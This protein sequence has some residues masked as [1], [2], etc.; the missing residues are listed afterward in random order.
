MTKR[1]IL[2]AFVLCITFAL[3]A[4]TVTIKGIVIG[5][6]T[7]TPIEN[8]SIHVKRL[9]IGT[10]TSNNGRFALQL[11]TGKHI[12]TV[13]KMGYKTV[14]HTISTADIQQLHFELA[15]KIHQLKEVSVTQKILR[16]KE[17][18]SKINV[19]A[20]NI[21]ITTSVVNNQLLQ[22]ADIDNVNDALRYTTGINPRVNYGG[23]QTF[24]MRGFG[25]PVFMIDG[26]RDERMN[27]S[28]SAPITSLA[29][30]D[31]IEYLKGPASVLYGHSAVGGILNIIRKKP[32][33]NFTANFAATYGSWNTKKVVLG[34]GGKINKSLTYRFDA[35]LSNS[36]GW[37][38][39]NTKY[40]NVY[41]AFNQKL[42]ENDN[43]E[44][45][46][47]ANDDFYGTETG[48]P[49]IN[50]DIIYD[51]WGNKIAKRGDLL[52]SF[53]KKQR[54]NDPNDFLKGKN[55]N[56][57]AKYIHRINKKSYISFHAS[58]SYDLIDYFSTESLSFPTS[59][60]AIYDHY[61]M[62]NDK[63]KYIDLKHLI[64]DY[65][66]RF[67][68]ETKTYQN[69]LEYTN[70]FN[71]G[72]ITHNIMGGYYFMYVDRISFSGYN[73]GEDVYGDGL[74]A[75]ITIQNPILNQGNLESKFS[76]ASLYNEYVNSFYFHDLIDISAKIKAMI[77][78]R[79]DFYSMNYQKA[80]VTEGRNISEKTAK[81]SILNTPLSYRV[82]LVYKPI[83]SLSV[84][85]SI[86]SFFKPQRSVY[87]ENYIYINKDG[88]VFFPKDGEEVFKPE[89]G[90]QAEIGAKY[91]FRK[92]LQLSAAAYYIK[93]ENI[94]QYLGKSKDNK[95]IYGQIGVV[96][97]KG[98]ELEANITTPISGLSVTT[99]YGYC[100]A[101]YQKF[102]TNKYNADSKEGNLFSYSPRNQFYA[103]SFYKIPSG[104]L[105]NL[106]AGF[107]INYTDKQ[108]TNTSNTYVLPSHWLAE[109]TLGYSFDNIY[110]KL[111][112]NNL[113]NKSYF[114]NS[115]F[116]SQFVPGRER[117]VMFT[118]GLKL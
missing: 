76:A 114:S 37:R 41:V 5:K 6:K 43:L 115:I 7:K 71:T 27:F 116:S 51:T 53:H 81:K 109:A 82:G 56:A 1:L 59:D 4:Q 85:A 101:T 78:M 64:R 68:H 23:F 29:A 117:N 102:S 10:T 106:S 86:A 13:S 57:S 91:K 83:E 110:F 87:N 19:A 34:A 100:D 20:Q 90:Y 58:Y 3:K 55:Y 72:N 84:Y 12:I 77:G 33:D 24:K 16:N 111:K 80:K 105:Q 66:L 61:Y 93:K 32:T 73:L 15:Q 94:K 39:N 30:V 49:V 46:L 88:D 98:F 25:S 70:K 42:S 40:S 14:R 95:R 9:Q 26:S 31:R 118:V 2:L 97:S 113:F 52:K 103:W 22:Q 108:Y 48:L 21:P 69:F 35:S 63:K 79:I 17:R 112:V 99:G 65:P 44:I 96:D 67:S 18:I 107:G 8:V 74:Y 11:P 50:K 38:D 104:A 47:G 92:W 36:D 62:S 60:L 75:K 28:S 89:S 45:R 54:Y